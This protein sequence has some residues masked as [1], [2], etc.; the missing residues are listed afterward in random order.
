MGD[1]DQIIAE[2]DLLSA[3]LGKTIAERDKAERAADLMTSV[4]LE[5]EISWAQHDQKWREAIAKASTLKAEL[6]D[7]EDTLR[8][9]YEADMRAIKLWQEAHPGNDLVWPD[10]TKLVSWLLEQMPDHEN[11]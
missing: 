11:A 3:E 7:L 4:L 8:M 9:V 5:E 10:R 2:R 1:I 6:N